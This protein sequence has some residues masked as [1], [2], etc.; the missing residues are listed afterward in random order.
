MKRLSLT[1]LPSFDT[2]LDEQS[3]D[4]GSPGVIEVQVATSPTH[5][6]SKNTEQYYQSTNTAEELNMALALREVWL[7]YM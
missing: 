5:E 2:V 4:H 6:T 3:P 7:K 1:A